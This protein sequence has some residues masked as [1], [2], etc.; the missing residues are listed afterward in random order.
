MRHH[1]LSRKIQ[2]V[3]PILFFVFL[4]LFP[5]HLYSQVLLNATTE[6]EI[7]VVPDTIPEATFNGEAIHITGGTTTPKNISEASA[8]AQITVEEPNSGSTWKVGREETIEWTTSGV[9]GDVF[10]SLYRG[11]GDL[12][13]S[14]YRVTG[15]GPVQW[16]VPP[17]IEPGNNYYII[18][19]S[20]ENPN[21]W[22]R[23]DSTFT[24]EEGT[25]PYITMLSPNGG[26]KWTAGEEEE[27]RWTSRNIQGEVEIRL[28][29]AGAI[30]VEYISTGTSDDG[31]YN[32]TVP[33]DIEPRTDYYVGVT[34]IENESVWDTRSRFQIGYPNS[35]LSGIINTRGNAWDVEVSGNY[36]YIADEDGGLTVADISNPSQPFEVS[37]VETP[38]RA[39][40]IDVV[41]NFAYVADESGGLRVFNIS[42]PINPTEVGSFDTVNE[43]WG[44]TISGDNAY[45]AV[46]SDG[47]Q[48]LDISDP[49]NPT[50]VSRIDTPGNTVNVRVSGNYA[51]VAD[52]TGGLRILDISDPA[53]P[54]EVSFLSAQDEIW[55]IDFK[56]THAYVADHG[57]RVIDISDP[58]NPTEVS[59]FETSDSAWDVTVS[60][61]Y[62]YIAA[63]NAGIRTIDVSDPANP[64]ETGYFNTPD[65]AYGVLSE[66][67]Y[68]YIAAEESGVYIIRNQSDDDVTPPAVPTGLSASLVNGQITLTWDAN[69]V[70]DL[71]E[72]R[73][74]RFALPQEQTEL[75]ATISAGT[76]TY[77]DTDVVNGRTYSY[78]VS[79]VDQNGNESGYSK[80]VQVIMDDDSQSP[81]V[82]NP[83]PNQT[84]IKGQ[85]IEFSIP[86]NTF[87]DPNDD[88]FSLTASLS[89]ESALPSWLNFTDNGDGSGL[90]SGTPLSVGEFDI[91]VTATDPEGLSASDTFTL[92]V[93]E[94]IATSLSFGALN[95]LADNIQQTGDQTYLLTGNVSVN[96][97]LFV[98]GELFANR[99]QL[100][101]QSDGRIY[102]KEIPNLGNVTLYDGAFTFSLPDA[103]SRFLAGHN[104]NSSFS[105][106][107]VSG[108]LI[109]LGSLEILSDGVRV[110]GSLKMPTVFDGVGVDVNTLQL[111]K[112]SGLQIAGII[113]AEKIPIGTIASLENL[114]LSYDSIENI[115]SGEAVLKT[116]L[117]DIGAETE[118]IEGKVNKI[119]VAVE[120]GNP[121][122]I[123]TTGL[124]LSGGS[125]LI[126]GLQRPPKEL[127][128]GVSIAPVGGGPVSRAISLDDLNVTY[129]FGVRK[130]KGSGNMSV[131]DKKLSNA[132]LEASLGKVKFGGEANLIDILM[133]NATVGISKKYNNKL[134]LNGSLN[135]KLVLTKRNDGF[136]YDLLDKWIGLPRTYAETQNS[137]D[138]NG[139]SGSLE[140]PV[141]TLDYELNWEKGKLSPSFGVNLSPLNLSIFGKEYLESTLIGDNRF[142]NQSMVIRPARANHKMRV[143]SGSIEQ[144]F[145]LDTFQ[146]VLII[147]LEG[148]DDAPDFDVVLP[149]GSVISPQDAVNVDNI[150]FI[151]S[152]QDNKSFYIFDSPQ[153]G[154]WS[155]DIT[156]VETYELDLFGS[157]A[158]PSIN[159]NLEGQQQKGSKIRESS[160]INIEWVG[161]DPDDDAIISLYYDDGNEGRNG[162]LIEDNIPE[163]SGNGSVEWDITNVPTGL[164]HVYA[165]IDDN[166][167]APRFTYL[168][169]P[170]EVVN[171]N[172]PPSP[173]NVSV[174]AK[175]TLVDLSWSRPGEDLSY[176]I[177]YDDKSEPDLNSQFFMVEDTNMISIDSVFVPGKSY[178]L[179]ISSS[180]ETGNESSLSEIISFSYTSTSLNNRPAIQEFQG[181]SKALEGIT[182]SGRLIAKDMDGDNLQYSLSNAPEGMMIN[183]D[184]ELQ[185]TPSVDQIGINNFKIFVSDG[186]DVDS[187]E[188]TV[189]AVNEESSKGVVSFSRSLYDNYEK[190]HV[191]RLKDINVNRDREKVDSQKVTLFSYADPNGIR[192]NLT[193]TGKNT[194]EFQSRFKLTEFSSNAESKSLKVL[195]TDTIRV[196]YQDEFPEAI[197]HSLAYFNSVSTSIDKENE[198]SLPSEIKL[199]QNYPN[200][201]NP[202][203]TIRYALPQASDVKLEV[204][205]ILG[206]R[207]ALLADEQKSAGWHTATFDASNLSSG[208]Y[209]YRLQAGEFVQTRK[210]TLIK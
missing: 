174:V 52:Y 147:R 84:E 43:A 96:N 10:I 188:T 193:E 195:E 141:L 66:G 7:V 12:V 75:V 50:E 155:L 116:Q 148:P 19:Y 94:E 162:I 132:F 163:G 49:A 114:A 83:I 51:F 63:D 149:N 203:T 85:S 35:D 98:E 38:G 20:A 190:E 37:S 26:E 105:Q 90:F 57:L 48:I 196:E 129:T 53:N 3:F 179:A 186:Q 156:G 125:G 176:Q 197:R 165:K 131:F 134:N 181:E 138:L 115:F 25:G 137:L 133:G 182:Y 67:E 111:T 64:M 58:V 208:M 40:T 21:V 27:I 36:A 128:L 99:N 161:E 159:L 170:I 113:E 135:A 172:A 194:G 207:V 140:L 118:V 13:R 123:G 77:T 127:S 173:S 100:S 30:T 145:T 146:K 4:M 74:Y 171:S 93:T 108:L 153:S 95:L 45:V 122:P 166:V 175:D 177:Y 56:G 78:W 204:F 102:L 210:L 65:P 79:S 160:S 180:N 87:D 33:D 120:V 97:I 11:D 42:D 23:N 189:S 59:Y 109:E 41:S 157:N 112:S 15:S 169:Q 130:F 82:V 205:N 70:P 106:F 103:S 136:P 144:S 39:L 184:G 104:L 139:V 158:P 164:Y 32:W 46:E 126:N 206:Q 91:R 121:V 1:L 14:I 73:L 81:T 47:L 54:V 101:L 168:N 6:S 5:A 86:S 88:S 183:G 154:E 24:I 124:G 17:Y 107:Q 150:E 44:V 76:E 80:E 167:N 187:L 152:E 198:P 178:N 60:G 201:F 151:K 199:Q 31:T 185:W 143:N 117:I 142:E 119:G 62:A 192:I 209:I 68:V 61:N 72:Y 34:S 28:Y 8:S 29:R 191:I 55:D 16:T 110:E 9:S 18:I 89:D 200:P 202:T 69:S 92:T 2:N 71:A 22:D